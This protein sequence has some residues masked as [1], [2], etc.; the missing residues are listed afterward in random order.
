MKICVH[1]TSD[2]FNYPT[3]EFSN[4]EEFIQKIL[5]LMCKTTQD[6]VNTY[7]P[8][9]WDVNNNEHN[10][11]KLKSITIS[12]GKNIDKETISINE[13]EKEWVIILTTLEKYK[14]TL[15]LD[16]RPLGKHFV[17]DS[18]I[19]FGV[20]LIDIINQVNDSEQGNFYL[21]SY[22]KKNG[23][24][25]GVNQVF[26]H[27]VLEMLMNPYLSFFAKNGNEIYSK[28][29]C[30]AVS[31]NRVDYFDSSSKSIV[32]M[33]D[34]L[35]PAYFNASKI[36]TEQTTITS[37]TSAQDNL[38]GYCVLFQDPNLDGFFFTNPENPLDGI[39][40]NWHHVY[41]PVL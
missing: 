36:S 38:K 17:D 5:P 22:Q 24:Y 25:I 8:K 37:A 29:I 16:E 39:D 11:Y 6:Y 41:T 31:F 34:F 19:P 13:N 23:M 15:Q 32:T 3:I 1:Y 20:V 26:C 18:G 27:E 33:S 2:I 30:D 4:E 40:F 9:Y 7:L 10:E 21:Q 12:V 35:L 28:E 14:S